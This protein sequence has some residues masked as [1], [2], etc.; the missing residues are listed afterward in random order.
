MASQS[1]DEIVE[2]V[3]VDLESIILKEH[4]SRISAYSLGQTLLRT[5]SFVV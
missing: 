1:A 5:K 3:E 4:M 2:T